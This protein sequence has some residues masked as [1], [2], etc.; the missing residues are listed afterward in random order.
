[1]PIRELNPEE[2]HLTE[3]KNI[4]VLIMTEEEVE[5]MYAEMEKH[6]GVLPSVDHEPKR[7]AYYVK[8]FKYLQNKS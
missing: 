4:L 7:F 2:C 8:L 6:F 1:L 5:S 3:F